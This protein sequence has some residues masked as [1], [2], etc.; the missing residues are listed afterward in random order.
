VAVY[1]KI[2]AYL[3]LAAIGGTVFSIQQPGP[4]KAE[5]ASRQASAAHACEG[6]PTLE[7]MDAVE[8]LKERKLYGPLRDAMHGA[9]YQIERRDAPRLGQNRPTYHASNPRNKL[10]AYF[11]PSAT[12]IICRWNGKGRIGVADREASVSMELTGYGYGQDLTALGP[13]EIAVSDQ[14]IQNTRTADAGGGQLVTEWYVNKPD[15]LEQGFTIAARPKTASR[16]NW[17]G[18]SL[19]VNG[20]LRARQQ[21]GG[22]GIFLETAEGRRVL[23]Y[24]G[25]RAEDSR[26]RDLAADMR[27]DGRKVMLMVDDQQATYP[28]SIDP[29]FTFQQELT[30]SDGQGGDEFASSVSISGD[31]ALI[32]A[33]DATVEG[34]MFQ[35]AAYVF[36]NNGG[37]WS[38]QQKLTA[39]DG[40][41]FDFFGTSVSISGDTALIGAP[42]APAGMSDEE[43]AAYIFVKNG[44]GWS[45]Q[46]ILTASDGLGETEFG[47]SVSISGD[48]AL[49]GAPTAS[50]GLGAAYVFVSNGGAWSQQQKLSASDGQ[51]GDKFGSAVSISGDTALIGAVDAT[52]G[53][54]LFQGTAYV[55][56]N[57][58]GAWSQQQ[59]LTASDG[60]A[61]DEFGSTVSISGNTVLVGTVD[62]N[63]FLGAAYVFVNNGGSW[64]QQQEL[65]AS[66]GFE[67]DEF[68]SSVAISGNTALVGAPGAFAGG[69]T[70]V[71]VGNSG[72][73]SLQQ[74][75]NASDGDSFGSS[76][77]ISGNTAL[78][79]AAGTTGGNL[80]QGAAYIFA[81]PPAGFSLSPTQTSQSV[82]PGSSVEFAVDVD[83][84]QGS[85]PPSTDVALSASVAPSGSGVTATFSPTSVETGASSTLTVSADAAAQGG[86]YTVTITGTAGS[87][88]QT[89]SVTV[90]VT[91]PGFTLGFAAAS[92]PAPPGAKVPVTVEINRTGGFKGKVK[93]SAPSG[94]PAGVSIKGA[95][96]Q[97]TKG[98]SLTF[99]FKIK[100]TA[101][102]GPVQLTF[103][104]ADAAGQTTTASVTLV[105]Q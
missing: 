76:V 84:V 79:G 77:S 36:V 100:P 15:G 89:A 72:V 64:S 69:A 67:G 29:T 14:R 70:Y 7:G 53:G 30:A 62:A 16:G 10:D 34:K 91:A 90:T 73:W 31:T 22:K 95:S 105:V 94:L 78:I 96:T 66:D 63:F 12:Q 54:E 86:A 47:T 71:F 61:F 81:G 93:V 28:L 46:Q 38:Q 88:T 9:I 4:T 74:E 24:G 49:V 17:L 43:G 83:N 32:G 52:V 42:E 37:V 6:F 33:P 103:T 99:N 85:P 104:G 1:I 92:I 40:Q 39:S 20:S 59:K 18:I 68:G 101:A 41:A 19:E 60:Q 87:T 8:R 23:Q 48:S 5:T 97:T 21:K 44:G 56:A 58:S 26:G 80:L 55:F 51:L 11:T 13:G 35:G 27:V 98:N 82:A 102:T 57:N 2:R 75:L 45:Q 3:V 25:L 65:T 50:V